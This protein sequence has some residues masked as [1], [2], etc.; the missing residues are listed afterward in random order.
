MFDYIALTNN[1]RRSELAYRAYCKNKNYHHALHIFHAN[2]VVYDELNALLK[3]KDLSNKLLEETANYLFHLE[4]WFLQFSILERETH[5]P[6][7]N[8]SFL[9]LKGGIAYP[10]DFLEMINK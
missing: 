8:F 10:S 3:G 4:D 9:A 7:Q 6:E 1:I 2:E 5:K